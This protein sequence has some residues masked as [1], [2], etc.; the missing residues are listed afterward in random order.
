[1]ATSAMRTW[2]QDNGW[3][4][5]KPGVFSNPSVPGYRWIIEGD[6]LRWTQGATDLHVYSLSAFE[7]TLRNG[8]TIEGLVQGGGTEQ[9]QAEFSKGTRF[10]VGPLPHLVDADV[11]LWEVTEPP[12]AAGKPDDPM[13]AAKNVKPDGTLGKKRRSQRL[14]MLRKYSWVVAPDARPADHKLH[15]SGQLPLPNAKPGNVVRA[16]AEE[17]LEEALAGA[18]VLFRDP[19]GTG[20]WAIP[21]DMR[22]GQQPGDLWRARNTKD[23]VWL[24]SPG[25]YGN[26][27]KGEIEVAKAFV[28][29]HSGNIPREPYEWTKLSGSASKRSSPPPKPASKRPSPSNP[30]GRGDAVKYKHPTGLLQIGTKIVDQVSGDDVVLLQKFRGQAVRVPASE[31]EPAVLTNDHAW[32]PI[33]GDIVDRAKE[34]GKSDLEAAARGLTRFRRTGEEGQ[35]E[36][37]ALAHKLA[38]S[39]QDADQWRTEPIEMR[40]LDPSIDQVLAYLEGD[41]WLRKQL[42]MGAKL[43]NGLVLNREAF[44]ILEAEGLVSADVPISDL[45]PAAG[46]IAG[47][48]GAAYIVMPDGEIVLDGASVDDISRAVGFMR[49]VHD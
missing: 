44:K 35:R 28:A 6:R 41:D 7:K 12:Y 32:N 15:L 9:P 38:A 3:I 24:G 37:L 8:G 47:A 20:L 13:I 48:S 31:L 5:E 39:G 1:M 29:K 10:V 30:F 14:S 21:Y 36:Y 49:V 42:Q 33:V 22:E 2:L 40:I 23:W 4:E 45:D 27:S 46:V 16:M 11:G 34:K 26:M 17:E 18:K 43:D 25:W 19:V